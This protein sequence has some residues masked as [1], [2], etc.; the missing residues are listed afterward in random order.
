[1]SEPGGRAWPPAQTVQPS[2]MLKPTVVHPA[3]GSGEWRVY[4]V[5]T[6]ESIPSVITSV[7]QS[8]TGC[9]SVS[10]L[11]Q[12]FNG[13][14][15]RLAL[16]SRRSSLSVFIMP[17]PL[18]ASHAPHTHTHTHT[19]TRTHAHTHVSPHRRDPPELA[20]PDHF[21]QR[22]RP[23]RAPWQRAC[24]SPAWHNPTGWCGCCRPPLHRRLVL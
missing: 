5:C 10:S 17:Q 12:Q 22:L 24:R 21:S 1:M 4:C 18:C 20:N 19:H 13:L 15:P 14:S 2:C 3:N 11:V 8:A 9:L 7:T 16:F 6:D 23:H